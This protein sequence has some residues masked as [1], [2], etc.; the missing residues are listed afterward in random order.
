[1]KLAALHPSAHLTGF[2]LAMAPQPSRTG[3]NNISI[4]DVRLIGW[5]PG[6]F[7]R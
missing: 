3:E 4:A 2:L 7:C 5:Q 6:D 1:L